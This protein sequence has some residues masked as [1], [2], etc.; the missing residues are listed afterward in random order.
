MPTCP[1]VLFPQQT[2]D[3][4]LR[5]A[6]VCARPAASA[7][8]VSPE[9]GVGFATAAPVDPMPSCPESFAPQHLTDPSVRRA[10]E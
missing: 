5:M 8:A 2:T 4:S 10:H 9:I 1:D 3:W 6:H 7:D